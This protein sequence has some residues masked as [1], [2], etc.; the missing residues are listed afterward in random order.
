MHPCSTRG[1]P[2]NAVCKPTA[3]DAAATNLIRCFAVCGWQHR[4]CTACPCSSI[5]QLPLASDV[6]LQA[7]NSPRPEQ[8]EP[9]S[10]EHIDIIIHAERVSQSDLLAL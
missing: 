6:Q 7:S 8:E 10:R 1:D 3:V 9:G 2:D 4:G 5:S